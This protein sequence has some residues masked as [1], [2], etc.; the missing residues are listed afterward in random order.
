MPFCNSRRGAQLNGTS[1]TSNGF[2]LNILEGFLLIIKRWLARSMD[3]NP[4]LV[5]SRNLA[6]LANLYPVI[7]LT[8]KVGTTVKPGQRSKDKQLSEI[9]QNRLRG[10]AVLFLPQLEGS[11]HNSNFS[12]LPRPMKG[13]RPQKGHTLGQSREN[14]IWPQG[15]P[16]T[17]V[18]FYWPPSFER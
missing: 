1:V 3:N 5:C 4:K 8:I 18:V 17:Q 13:S 11:L 6:D 7:H 2:H 9:S 15:P 12:D 14:K 10:I 16:V